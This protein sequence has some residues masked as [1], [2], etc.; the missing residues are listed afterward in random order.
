[1][2]RKSH[3]K[4]IPKKDNRIHQDYFFDEF[5]DFEDTYDDCQRIEDYLPINRIRK[6]IDDDGYG[7]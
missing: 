5:D 2:S 7:Y 6:K 3:D 1:M 4:N